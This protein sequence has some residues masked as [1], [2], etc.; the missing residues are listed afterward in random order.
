MALARDEGQVAEQTTPNQM[1]IRPVQK[2]STI[3]MPSTQVLTVQLT[4]RGNLR[5]LSCHAPGQITGTRGRGSVL[6][7]GGMTNSYSCGMRC[8]QLYLVHR[9][10]SS[11]T[12]MGSSVLVLLDAGVLNVICM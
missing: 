6:A 3:V 2:H 8:I 1:K 9:C 11:R 7:I 5:F 12:E 10:Y 4:S